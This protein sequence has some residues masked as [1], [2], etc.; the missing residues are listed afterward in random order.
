MKKKTDKQKL[1]LLFFPPQPDQ[2]CLE[3]PVCTIHCE[4]D[5]SNYVDA[6]NANNLPNVQLSLRHFAPQVHTLLQSHDGE[7]PLM[8]WAQYQ[9]WGWQDMIE[10]PLGASTQKCCTFPFCSFTVCYTAE[11]G[12]F[13]RVEGGVLLEHLISCVPG[14]KIALARSG[15]KKVQWAENKPPPNIGKVWC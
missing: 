10:K 1:R 3:S 9:T 14:V 2:E 13:R 15:I 4:R 12:N 5:S 11:F 6:L 7:M 8:R